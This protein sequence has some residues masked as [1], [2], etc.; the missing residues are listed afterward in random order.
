MLNRYKNANK[1]LKEFR[2]SRINKGSTRNGKEYTVFQIADSKKDANDNRIY[3]NWG[4]FVW[5][6]LDINEGDKITLDEISALDTD[7][8][9]V[10]GKTYVNKTIFASVTV[11]PAEPKA[12]EVVGELQPLD[13]LSGE[14]PF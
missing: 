11:I 4:V 9:T 10:N 1:E 6:N 12:V 2:V 7:T 8:K 14:L 3:D 13:D 5:H